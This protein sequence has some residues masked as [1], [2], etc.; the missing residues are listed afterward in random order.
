MNVSTT[1][2]THGTDHAN[3]D[4]HTMAGLVVGVHVRPKGAQPPPP[5]HYRPLRLTIHSRPGAYGSVDGFAYALGGGAPSLPGPTLML[6]KDEPVAVTIVNRSHEPAAVHWHGIELESFPDGVPGWSGAG[7]TV[8]PA[9]A[10]RDSLT[11]RFTPPR[12]GTF[13]YHS[14]FN[15]QQQIAT[16]LYGAIVVLPRG[17]RFDADTD[18]I[19]LFSDPGPVRINGVLRPLA[20]A[21]LNGQA[22][23]EPLTL[24]AGQTYRMRI[25]NIRANGVMALE[26]RD[27]QS[28]LE[29]RL[30]AKDGADVPPLHAVAQAAQLIVAAGEIYDV[31]FTPKAPGTVQLRYGFANVI[32]P[33]P[34]PLPVPPVRPPPPAAVVT[35]HVR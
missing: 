14:H 12:A 2:V 11:V 7:T 30:V 28:L 15:E 35:V 6:E 31:E 22:Q 13:M 9:I 5:S 33:P 1:T 17:Q 8:L 24:R 34:Q 23:P 16:G 18:R 25:I 29:W 4:N 3:G 32:R 20:N 10:P 27:A 26:L 19:L 21:L